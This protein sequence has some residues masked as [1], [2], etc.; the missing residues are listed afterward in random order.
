MRRWIGLGVAGTILAASGS[1][2]AQP[3]TGTGTG[4]TTSGY[5][6][7]LTTP[8]VP[9]FLPNGTPYALRAA[10]LNPND[11]NFQ[12]CED[13][14]ILQFNLTEGGLGA[15][16]SPDILEIWAGAT[17]CTQQTARAGA[18]SPFCWQ[19]YPAQEP[20]QTA[21]L[22]IYARSLTR[23]VDT[24]LTSVPN[25]GNPVVGPGQP[26]AACHTQTSSGQVALTI[27]FMFL[28]NA[29]D[30]TPD[31]STSYSLNVDLVGPLAP[32]SLTAGIGD[33]L[34]LINWTPQIDPTIQGFNIYAEDQGPN[35]L[36][37]SAEAGAAALTSQ[38]FCHSG[39]TNVCP[40]AG[41]TDGSTDADTADAACTTE[42][43]DGSAYTEVLDASS[44]SALS[45]ASLAD[46]G[47]TRSFPTRQITTGAPGAGTCTS[48]ALVDV[49]SSSVTETVSSDASTSTTD[50][51]V[52]TT[53]FEGGVT[54][55]VVGIS[56]VDYAKYGVG[57]VGGNTTSSYT[58][59]T[60]TY[61]DGGSGPLINGHQYA[62]AVAATDE[63]GNIGLL[64]P[65]ACQTPE[66]IIDFWDQ[67]SKDGGLAGGGFCALE[68]PGVHVAGSVFGTF[69]GTALLVVG[70]RR[71]RRNS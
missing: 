15:T 19:V 70:R 12:D 34:L 42:Y 67:Y 65:L 60:V 18:E 9:R 62:I 48:S 7:A 13:N 49:F 44:L 43:P 30:A 23:Y 20:T 45:D 52:A 2:S 4:T 55:S 41:H 38:I 14:I 69:V 16:S 47:C 8:T 21:S 35:G 50:G 71:R 26:E 25:G 32:T 28:A 58:I 51:S 63:D 46:M 68:A 31:A 29:G 10:N 37:L 61:P 1:A 66:P 33:G 11:I 24:T 57:M 6:V 64:S 36:G 39:G 3:G 17:D 27:Y 22:N 59:E 56:Q 54:G 5:S 53:T 40:D